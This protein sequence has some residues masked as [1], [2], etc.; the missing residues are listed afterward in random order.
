MVFAEGLTFWEGMLL[1]YF[2]VIIV[3]DLLIINRS[4]HNVRIEHL[5]VDVTVQ[6]GDFWAEIFIIRLTSF[7]REYEKELA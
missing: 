4:V 7:N 5:W 2:R 3:P 6:V 1:F